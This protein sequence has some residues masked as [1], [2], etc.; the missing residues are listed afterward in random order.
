TKRVYLGLAAGVPY[1]K[2]ASES[3]DVLAQKVAM[4]AHNWWQKTPQAMRTQ[5]AM[6]TQGFSQIGMGMEDVRR[7]GNTPISE[8]NA[9]SAQYKKDSSTLSIGGKQ[10]Q[11]WY[12]LTRSL[13]LAGQTIETVLITKLA[14]LAPVLGHITSA[15]TDDISALIK[16]ITPSD[17]NKFANGIKSVAEYLGSPAVLENLKSFMGV[18][19]GFLKATGH[20]V[21]AFTPST[22]KD[23]S[24]YAKSDKVNKRHS[25]FWFKSVLPLKLY[26]SL[27]NNAEKEAFLTAVE[28][29][30]KLPKG[31]ADSVWAQE[32]GRGKNVG[33]SSAGAI[34]NFQL[35]PATAAAY[36]VNPNK[37]RESAM[38]FGQIMSENMARYHGNLK[39]ALA[40]YNAGSGTVDK[41]IKAAGKNGDWQSEMSKYQSP[42]NYRETSNYVQQTMAR[43]DRA[44]N[45]KTPTVN[46]TITNKTGADI[47][48]STNAA[49]R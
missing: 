19:E 26:P 17:I 27:K 11:E 32:S 8:L 42:K 20:A 13:K 36:H 35:M 1:S 44:N 21:S 37:F 15:L 22:A 16:G 14:Q 7:L 3:P 33:P 49:A 38:G 47:Y 45:V 18:I 41:A 46:V 43:I 31:V 5:Q 48:S 2:A 34:G 25:D 40:A 28:Q 6:A 4:R 23:R 29:K 39:Q 12:Q 24:D 9:A 10:T 30:Y